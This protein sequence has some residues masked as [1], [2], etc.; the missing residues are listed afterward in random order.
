MNGSKILEIN[1]D[2]SDSLVSLPIVTFPPFKL[3][4]SLVERDPVVWVHLL[5]TYNMYMANLISNKV[6]TRLDEKTWEQL[7]LF[8]RSYLHELS[9]EKGQLLSLGHNVDV[10]KNLEMLHNWCFKLIQAVGSIFKLQMNASTLWDFIRIYAEKSPI[11]VRKIISGSNERT[12][13]K[14]DYSYMIHN[15]IEYLVGSGKFDRFDLKTLE[16]LVDNENINKIQKF[17]GKKDFE[18]QSVSKFGGKSIRERKNKKQFRNNNNSSSSSTKVTDFVDKFSSIR[19]I[20]ILEELYADGKGVHAAMAKKLCVLTL[21]NCSI[22]RIS[23]IA[24]ELGINSLVALKLYPLFG[25]ILWGGYYSGKYFKTLERRLPFL[26]VSISTKDDGSDK[27]KDEDIKAVHDV[28]P[29]LPEAHLI[30]LLRQYGTVELVINKIFENPELQMP[31][32]ESSS[33]GGGGSSSIETRPGSDKL[34]EKKA[35][36]DFKTPLKITDK[37]KSKKSSHLPSSTVA[38]VP[39]AV[40]NKTLTAAL[41]LLYEADEDEMDDTYDDAQRTDFNTKNSNNGNDKRDSKYNK[42]EEYLWVLLK[43]DAGLFERK[44]RKSAKRKD[45]KSVT[46]WSDEQ[47][48]GW[49]RMIQ[50]SPLRAQLLE[51]KFMFVNPNKVSRNDEGKEAEKEKEKEEEEEEEEE[52]SNSSAK[53]HKNH[54]GNKSKN[55]GFSKRQYAKNEKNKSSKANHNRKMGHDKKMARGFM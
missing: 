30:S 37:I 25:S 42:I 35:V 45:M 16:N 50:R 1:S 6:W 47:I 43:Q 18:T 7:C 19:W 36:G 48:E 49:A 3:R 8:L 13:N 14:I 55:V 17:Q 26:K 21:L 51:E 39:D 15:H 24:T 12:N 4:A 11:T 23:S 44:G 9:S 31:S 41:R 20:E 27:I 5:E 22:P 54:G 28:F 40:R 46:G 32:T 52:E 34:V 10:S 29:D 2:A 33:S 38:A 53:T